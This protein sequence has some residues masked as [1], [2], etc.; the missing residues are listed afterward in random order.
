MK[1]LLRILI[2]TVNAFLLAIILPGIAI[3]SIYTA[4]IVA[5]LLSVFDASVKPLLIIFT[6]PVTLITL[7]VFLFVIN[8]C[9]ILAAENFING[10]T[11]AGFWEA[12]LFS[13]LLSILNSYVHKKAFRQKRMARN[14]N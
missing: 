5:I 7:G 11:V 12:V 2:T 14:I 4:L 9:V 6:F 10:F 8:A 3:D 1:F 13:V